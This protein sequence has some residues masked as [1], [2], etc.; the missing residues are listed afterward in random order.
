MV[1]RSTFSMPF[2]KDF[3]GNFGYAYPILS[4]LINPATTLRLDLEAL[5]R[6]Q[7]LMSPAMGRIRIS[8]QTFFVP[9]RIMNTTF[10]DFITG[11]LD[12]LQAPAAPVV[13][14]PGGGWAAG[15]LSDFLCH[16]VGVAGATVSAY[17]YRAY[18]M[19]YNQ[20]G[21]DEQLMPAVTVATGAGTDSTTNLLLKRFCW[22]R[23]YYTMARPSPQLGAAVA[24]PLVGSAPVYGDGKT[25][26]LTDGTNKAGFLAGAGG[27]TSAWTGAYNQTVGSLH[28]SGTNIQSK[29]LGVVVKPD[30]S[31]LVADLTAV[32]GPTVEEIRELSVIMRFKERM[33]N[34]GARLVEFYQH[35]FGISP[36]DARLQLPE[37]LGGGDFVM[38]LSEI[39]QT[40]ATGDDTPLGTLAGHGIGKGNQRRIKYFAK[41][42]GI[43]MT[44][45][46]IRP[47]AQY[48]QGIPRE[49]MYDNK[50]D[51]LLPDFANLGDQEVYKGEIFSTGDASDREVW[52]YTPRYENELFIPSTYHG[53]FRKDQPLNYWTMGRQFTSRPSL[54]ASFV[55][56][57]GTDRIF[58]VQDEDQFQVRVR[59]YM[60]AKMPLPRNRTPRLK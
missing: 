41:E 30:V 27:P 59:G 34:W 52:A 51:Y 8:L 57:D 2:T 11:G 38:Q 39:L 33:N 15:S 49:D 24:V 31:G 26:G 28:A 56:C 32:A 6:S 54:N 1:A 40:S 12:G 9:L 29:D 23:D 45:M 50:F 22:R 19:I 18:G 20:Y 14:A 21:R 5:V 44:L 43:L 53:E 4:K 37:Y 46:I 16:P 58:A 55:E 7:P 10:E 47:D 17:K 36:Q 42:H 35:T 60:K 13:V 25:L 48:S 3:T